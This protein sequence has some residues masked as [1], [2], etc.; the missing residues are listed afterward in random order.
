MLTSSKT[1]PNFISMTC[2]DDHLTV[3]VRLCG[4]IP[5][6][7]GSFWLRMCVKSVSQAWSN[8][9]KMRKTNGSERVWENKEGKEDFLGSF[10]MYQKKLIEN[11]ELASITYL[12]GFL[13]C[14][15]FCEKNLS[16][17]Y[18][19]KRRVL[20]RLLGILKTLKIKLE[21]ILFFLVRLL[22]TRLKAVGYLVTTLGNVKATP[23]NLKTIRLFCNSFAKLLD[24]TFKCDEKN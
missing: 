14:L 5:L 3:V 24:L 1:V 18:C 13:G 7:A 23:T 9:R 2:L 16:T 20:E 17:L 12:N 15:G 4:K 22:P 8:R 11:V 10:Q 21:L 19:T 6:S